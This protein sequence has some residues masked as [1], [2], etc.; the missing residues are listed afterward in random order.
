MQAGQTEEQ[1][2]EKYSRSTGARFFDEGIAMLPNSSG[3]I[4]LVD[5]TLPGPRGQFWSQFF[6]LFDDSKLRR[7]LLI[8]S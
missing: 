3:S 8:N 4:P 2:H 6:R 7:L 5:L 1:N